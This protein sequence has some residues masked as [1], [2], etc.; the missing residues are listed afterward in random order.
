MNMKLDSLIFRLSVVM[1]GVCCTL[2]VNAASL[3]AAFVERLRAALPVNL[4]PFPAKATKRISPL[5]AKGSKSLDRKKNVPI[6][7]ANFVMTDIS[8]DGTSVEMS[9]PTKSDGEEMEKLWFKAEDVLGGIVKPKIEDWEA[10]VPYRAYALYDIK[11]PDLVS[12]I[13]EG[14]KGYRVGTYTIRK[15]AYPIVLVT[16]PS[17][18]LRLVAPAP[19]TEKKADYFLRVKEMKSEFAFRTGRAW[20]TGFHALLNQEGASECAGLVA[21]FARYLFDRSL[22]DQP[23]ERFDKAREIRAGDIVHIKGHYFAVFERKGNVLVTIE[24]NMNSVVCQSDSRYAII[25]D[26]TISVAG[27]GPTEFEFGLHYLENK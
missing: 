23:G 18:Q 21:D 5:V 12:W 27:R 25:D 2:S 20:G 14:A 13:S 16:E 8:E 24:G 19:R 22:I 10:K 26:R 15:K 7:S 6:G 4:R 1:L 11:T 9:V 17:A 3:D